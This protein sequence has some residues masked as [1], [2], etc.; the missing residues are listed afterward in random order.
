MEKLKLGNFELCKIVESVGPA[1]ELNFLLP[2]A[3]RET[4]EA[5]R[6]WLYPN[7]IDPLTHILMISFHSYLLRTGKYTI[8]ID[9]CV[10]NHKDR[11]GFPEMHKLNT[12]Y[13]QKLKAAG[14]SPD[15]IDFVMCTHMHPDH[16]G[17]NTQVEDGLWV[18]TFPNARYLFGKTEYDSWLHYHKEIAGSEADP[19][20]EV[21]S[22]SLRL[23]FEDS[24]LPVIAAGQAEMIEGGF[25][26]E[27][28][29]SVEDAAGHSPGNFVFKLQ[30]G[31]KRATVSGDVLHHPLQLIRPEWSSGF[32]SDPQL[33]ALT[34]RR[35]LGETAASGAILMPAHFPT[36]SW[37]KIEPSGDGFRLLTA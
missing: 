17:W 1:F 15:E 22:T 12:D 19:M 33:S 24:V 13:L 37:G 27:D 35:V 10:G 29:V 9:S 31:G 8:L 20:P 11:P 23:S 25:E 6:S 28:G 5:N 36:P 3:D 30:S 18:P 16:V 34:R 4:V 21:A 14:V 7:Y 32:C 26:L 2:D